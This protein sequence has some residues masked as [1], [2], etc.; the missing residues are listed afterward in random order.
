MF[1]LTF[2]TSLE[3]E[4]PPLA[5]RR[6]VVG[7]SADVQGGANLHSRRESIIN[8]ET[9][10]PGCDFGQGAGERESSKLKL[11]FGTTFGVTYL[12]SIS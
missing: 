11:L 9:L 1:G 8:F 7:D 5:W 4:R 12:I 10:Y 6:R 2:P 3:I